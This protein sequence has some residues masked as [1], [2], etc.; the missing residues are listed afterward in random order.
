M[1]KSLTKAP[2]IVSNLKSKIK[3][4]DKLQG[5]IVNKWAKYWKNLIGDYRQMLVDL[6][7]D[8]QDEPLKAMKWT[9]AI[10][11]LTFLSLKN[12]SE[13]DFKDFLKRINNEAVMVSPDCLNPKTANHLWYLDT[14]YNQGTIKYYSLGIFSIMYTTDL[15]ESCDLYKA[16]C[17]YLQ[18]TIFSLPSRIVDVGI[19][20]Q[21]WNLY[22]KTHDYDVNC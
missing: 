2:N 17:S 8:I 5:T 7:T 13:L 9:A 6:R 16:K 4:P 12:P 19:M 20:G 3:L 14:C 11:S 18:P 1:L 15:N 10:G 21:W 22:I